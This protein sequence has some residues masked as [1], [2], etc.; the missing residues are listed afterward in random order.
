MD[1]PVKVKPENPGGMEVPYQDRLVLNQP[2]SGDAANASVE[3]LLPPPET[4]KPV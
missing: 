3:R 2:Q 4:P 1:D